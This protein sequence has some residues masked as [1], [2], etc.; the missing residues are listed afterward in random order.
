MQRYRDMRRR[1]LVLALAKATNLSV[2]HCYHLIALNREP[3]N[4]LVAVVWRKVMK[5]AA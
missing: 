5:S 1:A 2:K 4:P 3:Q